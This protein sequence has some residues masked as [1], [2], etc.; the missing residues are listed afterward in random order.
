MGPR[1]GRAAGLCA[2]YA[3]PGYA[4][5]GFG[6]GFGAGLGRGRGFS[7]AGRGR[8][9]RYYATGQRGWARSAWAGPTAPDVNPDSERQAL[10]SQARA[11]KADLDLINKRL[12]EIDADATG[13]EPVA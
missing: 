9:N 5:T 6:R 7:G 8:R 4:N 1:T 10:R 2:G 12:A 13:T 3:M 11:L